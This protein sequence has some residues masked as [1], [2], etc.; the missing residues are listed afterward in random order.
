MSTSQT[1]NK[2]STFSAFRIT[3]HKNPGFDMQ[4]YSRF[5]FGSKDAARHFGEELAKAIFVA[6]PM[7]LQQKQ[8]VIC[9]SPYTF[10]PTAAFALKDYMI[11]E[12]NRL[13]YTSNPDNFLPIQEAKI[14]RST[15]YSDDYGSLDAKR[16]QELIGKDEFYIDKSFIEGKNVIFLDDIRI[17]G[18]HEQVIIKMIDKLG[19]NKHNIRL[20]YYAELCDI[21]A[22]PSFEN[23]LNHA[24]VKDLES[25]NAVIHAPDFLINTRVIKY[26]LNYWDKMEFMHWAR[27][28]PIGL[29][30]NIFHMAIGNGYH[31]MPEYWDN[32]AVLA[33][34][35]IGPENWSKQH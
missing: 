4:M 8:L 31:K 35:V 7:F 13:M 5:K 11:R 32:L 20:A 22:H 34:R 27:F 24:Y 26:L 23:V 17:T 33:N 3:D 15:S 12:L 9:S 2:L 25:L 28:Q 19:L 21:S 10:I 18:G 29:V 16:R 14:Y 6:I 30:S 1:N